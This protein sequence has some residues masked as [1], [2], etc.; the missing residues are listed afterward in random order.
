MFLFI[1]QHNISSKTQLFFEFLVKILKKVPGTPTPLY[2]I[3][4]SPRIWTNHK[5]DLKYFKNRGNPRRS[6]MPGI[7]MDGAPKKP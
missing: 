7:N 4:Y 3:L 2:E 1:E 5:N 6:G